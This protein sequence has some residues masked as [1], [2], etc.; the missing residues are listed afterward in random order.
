MVNMKD[1]CSAAIRHLRKSRNVDLIVT[2]N[3]MK[4]H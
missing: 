1:I 4:F 3:V 2:K